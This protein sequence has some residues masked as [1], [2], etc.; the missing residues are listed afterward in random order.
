VRAPDLEFQSFEAGIR[1]VRD[2]QYDRTAGFPANK[3]AIQEEVR[4]ADWSEAPRYR[5]ARDDGLHERSAAPRSLTRGTGLW[6]PRCAGMSFF[7]GLMAYLAAAAAISAVYVGTAVWLVTPEPTVATNAAERSRTSSHTH[8]ST[9]ARRATSPPARAGQSRMSV[10][11]V[12]LAP[13]SKAASRKAGYRVKHLA[14]RSR[15]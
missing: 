2:R 3:S 12:S 13:A 7:L 14:R 1:H 6:R 8:E 10:A 9:A 4:T 15:R 11:P 5:C